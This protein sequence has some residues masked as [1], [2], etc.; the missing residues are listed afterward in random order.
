MV[1]LAYTKAELAEHSANL[2]GATPVED[3]P[4]YPYGMSLWL[5]QE[6]L[7]K[8]GGMPGKVGDSLNV[9]GVVKITELSQREKADGTTEET[10][11]LQFTE[12]DF[13]KPTSK[14]DPKA[15]YPA[16]ENETK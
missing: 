16:K 10:L 9:T 3:M 13:G 12:F 8:L 4:K 2:S 5:S 15:M 11:N 6:L 14:Y 1:D 7:A